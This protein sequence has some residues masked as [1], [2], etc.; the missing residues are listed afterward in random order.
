[1][2]M[3]INADSEKFDLLK[4]LAD[5]IEKLYRQ[6]EDIDDNTFKNEFGMDFEI[7]DGELSEAFSSIDSVRD[8]IKN[9]D[10]TTKFGDLYVPKW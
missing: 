2:P 10:V 8:H 7:I 3:L 1:M 6:L 5:K 9:I 4:E